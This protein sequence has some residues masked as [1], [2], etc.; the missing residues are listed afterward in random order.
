VI[1]WLGKSQLQLRSS[2]YLTDEQ[3]AATAFIPKEESC[4][5]N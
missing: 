3:I 5:D 4:A 2:F 1:L